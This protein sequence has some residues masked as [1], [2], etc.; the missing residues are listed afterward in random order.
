MNFDPYD[1][2]FLED[3]YPTYSRLRNQSPVFHDP[4]WELTFFTRHDHVSAI[5]K[6]RDRFGRDFRHRLDPDEVDPDIYRRIYPPQWPTWTRYIRESFIDLE[7]PRHTRLRRLVS[8]AFTRRSSEAFRPRLEEAA[9]RI[10][11]R[12]IEAGTLDVITDFATPIP[13]TMIAELMGLPAEDH[14]QVL[15]WS[16]SIVKVFDQNV[17]EADGD[18][19]ESAT[20]DFVAY[21]DEVVKSR[22]RH[23]GED[24]ISSMV[25]VEDAGDTLTDEE[26]VGTSILTL[27][28]GHEATVHAIGNGLLA[29]AGDNGQYGR[30]HRRET[31]VVTAVDELLR[32]DS[33]LQMFERWVLVDTEV[34]GVSLMKGSKVGLLFGSA[35]HDPE[36]FGDPE[37]LDLAR[38]PNPHVSFGAGLHYCVGAPLARVELEAAFATFAARVAGVELKEATGRI[39]S[40]VFRGL[41]NLK[42]DI[43]AA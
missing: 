13:V 11:D 22:R 12:A 28:A 4:A 3:P 24:L 14:Q 42:L 21:L 43:E 38:Q 9:A 35:N 16:H 40:F 30:L 26:I 5:L 37:R 2:G 41:E 17:S 18:A 34:A 8:K 23:R 27:N 36:V 32:F 20:R 10:V 39:H 7:P 1:P 33:P 25:D 29:L 15:D 31:G 6:D 19:A